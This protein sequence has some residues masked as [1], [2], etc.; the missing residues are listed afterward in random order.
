MGFFKRNKKE[1]LIITIDILTKKKYNREWQSEQIGRLLYSFSYNFFDEV[2]L[3]YFEERGLF[4][5]FEIVLEGSKFE[6]NEI[7]DNTNSEQFIHRYINFLPTFLEFI[8]GILT[9]LKLK[10]KFQ[11]I[12]QLASS[13]K[14]YI[15]AMTL[16]M[17]KEGNKKKKIERENLIPKG[18]IM[19]RRGSAIP[20]TS[21]EKFNKDKTKNFLDDWK[22]DK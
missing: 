7:E 4:S 3:S 19:I 22:E 6:L 2:V 16:E 10:F 11:R 17:A 18:T 13:S 5:G 15:T 21:D 8:S 14:E 20:E 1:N 12:Q 9:N